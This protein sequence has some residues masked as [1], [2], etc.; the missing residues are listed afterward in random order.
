MEKFQ[1]R[2]FMSSP[3]MHGDEQIY[4]QEA[5]DTNWIAPLG[6]NVD[7]FERDMA[8]F[9]GCNG[10]TA[11][12][13]GTA[14]IH[15]AVKLAGVEKNDIVFCSDLTF[16]ATVNPIAYEGGNAVF[17]D[18]ERDTWNMDPEALRKAFQK[19]DNK[20]HEDGKLYR[21]P[22]AVIV[23]NLYGTPAKLDEIRDICDVY[24]T[25]LIEDA[26]E[27]LGATYKGKQTGRFGVY[28]AI[29]F[30]GNKI[31]T[32]SGGGMLLSDDEEA[33]KKAKFWATQARE[34]YPYYYHR[35]IGYNYRMSNIIAGIGR[36]QLL[37][38]GNHC[39]K[40]REIYEKY[41][42]GLKDLPLSMNPYEECSNP[43]FWLSCILLDEDCKITPD[44]IRIKLEDYNVESRLI[45]RPMHMQPVYEKNDFIT[46]GNDYVGEDIFRRGLCLPSDLKMTDDIQSSV[47]DIIRNLF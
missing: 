46:A 15:L 43:N 20:I 11:L 31:I 27:S 21:K 47:I 10:A 12:S 30:N 38:L 8:S 34:D 7:A 25:L 17:I 22:K 36:G 14:A 32:T 19:Y 18:A 5:F 28:N 4:I 2:V 26:A 41:K 1:N 23:A 29:S 39:K 13:S 35:E 3:T 42:E 9:V 6:T 45:W 16:A 44:E 33:L 37:H 40:K 24:D